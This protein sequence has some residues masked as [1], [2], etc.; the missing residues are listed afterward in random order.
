MTH[1]LPILKKYGL[2][3]T[4]N[5][6][7]GF[8]GKEHLSCCV[9]SDGCFMTAA[10][11]RSLLSS[12]DCRV[13][14]ANHSSDH[15]NTVEAIERGMDD[16]RALGVEGPIG[17]ASPFSGICAAN[18]AEFR[19]LFADG[20]VPYIRS[21]YQVRRDGR[22]YAALYLLFRYTK[23]RLFFR[24]YNRRNFIDPKSFDPRSGF[25]PSV[26]TSADSTIGQLLSLVK[27]LPDEKAM[28][29]NLHSIVSA[30]CA[31]KFYMTSDDFDT[32]CRTL[33]EDATVSVITN[34]EL[35]RGMRNTDA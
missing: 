2:P 11:L 32:L 5:V 22:L 16:L 12:P 9:E 26:A 34:A 20:R 28:I 27:H 13:E 1:A 17:F 15:S 30:P 21:G 33:R 6:I 18:F 4:L 35:V 25:L 29:I 19:P 7:T 14:I 24:L 31:G 23:S 8:L 10:E 3:S